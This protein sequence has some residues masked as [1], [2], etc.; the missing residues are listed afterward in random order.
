MNPGKLGAQKALEVT[1][2]AS[3]IRNQV[4]FRDDLQVNDI[5]TCLRHGEAQALLHT[6][7][8]RLVFQF[9]G[10]L[11]QLRTHKNDLQWLIEHQVI[12]R[13]NA[14]FAHGS[15]YALFILKTKYLGKGL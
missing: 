1:K 6:E 5:Q 3:R 14:G 7:P 12:S 4:R 13:G 15:D 11:Q 2:G 9:A 10:P 8:Q